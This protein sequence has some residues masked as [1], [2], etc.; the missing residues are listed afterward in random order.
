M[1]QEF[2]D[3][4]GKIV[5]FSLLSVSLFVLAFLFFAGEEPQKKEVVIQ[6]IVKRQ[7]KSQSISQPLELE[8]FGISKQQVE[9]MSDEEIIKENNLNFF[10]ID[11]MAVNIPKELDGAP[12]GDIE[13]FADGVKNKMKQDL[14]TIARS[15]THIDIS[16]ANSALTDKDPARRRAEVDPNPDLIIKRAYQ[17]QE[18]GRKVRNADANRSPEVTIQLHRDRLEVTTMALG[19]IEKFDDRGYETAMNS[20][21]SFIIG[22]E[23]IK[24]DENLE[25]S[26]VKE[27]IAEA[28][29]YTQ[30]LMG[31][32]EKDLKEKFPNGIPD[33]ALAKEEAEI[34]KVVEER[35]PGYK[36][37]G[38][39]K[40]REFR[41]DFKLKFAV[42]HLGFV[43]TSSK[44]QVSTVSRKIVSVKDC[45]NPAFETATYV[46]EGK[47]YFH[48]FEAFRES[49]GNVNE[50]I[51]CEKVGFQII[52]RLEEQSGEEKV[53]ER[54]HVV[55]MKFNISGVKKKVNLIQYFDP[56]VGF[57]VQGIEGNLQMD[58]II[59]LRD[60]LTNN[61]ARFQAKFFRVYPEDRVFF[62]IP[63]ELKIHNF[64]LSFM[65]LALAERPFI[66]FSDGSTVGNK[67]DV[68]KE[69]QL[70][71]GAFSKYME[72][73]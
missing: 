29:A 72:S 9:D 35:F 10:H 68:T 18:I 36:D 22:Y 65:Y 21:I 19:Y 56:S 41:V 73:R 70:E 24:D 37:P 50:N 13:A 26:D 28:K 51:V 66:D 7:K 67:G 63:H 17:L 16:E 39:T 71:L 12:F 11:S 8:S 25:Y 44:G 23:V 1:L 15:V 55:E 49:L 46:K 38:P 31:Q 52:T 59:Y 40:R 69:V 3:K 53:W 62:I 48:N 33:D 64:T 47:L 32:K 42:E 4:Y 43:R 61:Y 34:Q 60:P 2:M 27:T 54:D 57:V 58:M 6:K 45:S 30:E 20:H 5:V 14:I